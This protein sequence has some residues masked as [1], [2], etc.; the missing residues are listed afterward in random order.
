MSYMLYAFVRNGAVQCNRST[1]AAAE[2]FA[3]RTMGWDVHFGRHVNVDEFGGS[4][5]VSYKIEEH[6]WDS[7]RECYNRLS[8]KKMVL[9]DAIQPFP[10]EYYVATGQK[11]PFTTNQAT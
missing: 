8:V 5:S 7:R 10:Q 2:D 3:K 9:E 1:M 6:Q 4:H 11:F